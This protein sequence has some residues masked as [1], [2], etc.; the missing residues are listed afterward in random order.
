M[1]PILHVSHD[2]ALILRLL[3][4]S[5]TFLQAAHQR[6]FV[7]AVHFLNYVGRFKLLELIGIATC[8]TIR[9]IIFL[10]FFDRFSPLDSF[11]FSRF[12]CLRV[13]ALFSLFGTCSETITYGLVLALI[14]L[15]R[16]IQDLVICLLIDAW[17]F[18]WWIRRISFCPAATLSCIIIVVVVFTRE[19]L[20]NPPLKLRLFLAFRSGL[21]LLLCL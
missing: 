15:G 3:A 21:L 7:I 19:L 18:L 6:R 17:K 9:L 10:Y 2:L 1:E 12:E 14:G 5:D 13:F 4:L 20:V 11:F 16:V 8:S